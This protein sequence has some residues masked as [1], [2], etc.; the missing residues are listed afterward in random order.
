MNVLCTTYAKPPIS[1]IRNHSVQDWG[2]AYFLELR[3]AEVRLRRILLPGTLVNKGSNATGLWGKPQPA[4][5]RLRTPPT[6]R[7]Y[8]NQPAWPRL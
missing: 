8:G 6:P 7:L 3:K 2:Y 1:Y 4:V 5:A